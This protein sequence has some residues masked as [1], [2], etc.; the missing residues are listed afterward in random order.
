MS[1][2]GI[3]LLLLV[4]MAAFAAFTFRKLSLLGGLQ[5]EV[6]WND[7]FERIKSVLFNGLLLTAEQITTL[8]ALAETQSTVSASDVSRALR[9]PWE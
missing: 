3:S 7:P 1:P 6:R 2:I 8:K 5:P 4:S 9:G